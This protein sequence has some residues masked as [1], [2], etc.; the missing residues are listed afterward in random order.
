MKKSLSFTFLLLFLGFELS[1]AQTVYTFET[2][3][4]PSQWVVQTGSLTLNQ[5]HYKEGVQSLCWKTTGTSSLT[6][7]PS[8]GYMT[9]GTNGVDFQLHSPV[10]TN[11]TLKVDF[12]NGT[13][14]VRS[15]RLCVN[16]KGWRDICRAYTEFVSSAATSISKIQ[17]TLLPTDK[18]TAR[19]FY[20]DDV[21]LAS[22]IPTARILGTHWI[23]DTTYF[24]ST[25][26]LFNLQSYSYPID[27][28]TTTPTA[29]ELSGLNT[30]KSN[31][32][33]T[34]APTVGTASELAAAISFTDSLSITRNSDGSVHGLPLNLKA[35]NLT[36]AYMT[37]LVRNLE[38]LAA[39]GAA[40]ATRF[41]N[42]LDHLLDQGFADGVEYF[43]A[44]W[45]YTGSRLIPDPLFSILSS[46]STS[47]KGEVLKLC[48]WILLYGD[49]YL[50]QNQYLYSLNS[51]RIYLFSNYFMMIALNQTT[52]ALSVRELKA[53][54]R[55]LDRNGQYVPGA[56][57]FL[58]IDGTGFHHSTPYISYMIAYKGFVQNMYYL[59]G[60]PFKVDTVTYNHLKKAVISEFM[61]GH[62]G[63]I[64]TEGYMG[65]SLCGRKPGQRKL[66]FT[67]S[68]FKNF[69][70]VSTD[71]FGSQDNELA[72]AYNYVYQSTSYKVPTPANYNGFY[73]YNYGSLGVYRQANWVATMRCPTSVTKGSEIFPSENRFGRYQSHGSLEVL[74]NGYDV[75]GY[76]K[77]STNWGGWDW[78]M[79]PGTTTVQYTNWSSLMP[80]S[81]VGRFD[82]YAKTKNFSGALSWGDIGLFGCDFDQGDSWGSFSFSPTN[83]VFKKSILA[84]DGLLID[85]G[86]NISSTSS[87]LNTTTNLFQNIISTNSQ[88]LQVNGTS[89]STTLSSSLVANTANSFITPTGTGYIIP[90]GNDAINVIYGPQTTPLHTGA[91]VASPTTTLTAAKAFIVHGLK[92]SNKTYQFVVV[93]GTTATTLS[94][95]AASVNSGTTYQ[96]V[97]A[98]STMHVIYYKPRNLMAYTFFKPV[99]SV[100]DTAF[101][102]LKSISTEA[103]LL[104]RKTPSSTTAYDFAIANPNLR[105]IS[106]PNFGWIATS[107]TSVLTLKGKW[108]IKTGST[109]VTLV[110]AS[111]LETKVQIILSEGKPQYFTMDVDTTKTEV[112]DACITEKP[113]VVSDSKSKDLK[114]YL[115]NSDDKEV[116]I[117]LIYTDGTCSAITKYRIENGVVVISDAP[118]HK[119]LN[120]VKVNSGGLMTVLK[121]IH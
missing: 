65:L 18:L 66:T 44:P 7:T 91:D 31:S 107:T 37:K 113:Y 62:L 116:E 27:I 34:L 15:M 6:I 55:W 53:Y 119:G 104:E 36:S 83:L 75:S 3:T 23:N 39:D 120:L 45:D 73:A 88:A 86:S 60:T 108:L 105:P 24:S 69:I 110:S 57:D 77:D 67:Q 102:I 118:L 41:N 29:S 21:N 87:T 63:P 89:V 32:T 14:I 103:L 47:Q 61:M 19:T 1:F 92:P 84:V 100:K 22:T 40:N 54:K 78:N 9:S 98:D 43:Q 5:E 25:A 109:A 95:T 72:A 2:T 30:L 33:F 70:S 99:A 115:G 101:H 8:T 52:T 48:K 35:V 90:K 17:L 94:T 74:Y 26:S 64:N 51:D 97:N 58:K 16:F 49:F 82:Q 12:Y 96:L 4:V 13:T 121:V 117:S 106:D 68:Y 114:I 71:L 10:I 85:I 76:P 38:V 93:P 11:D 46:C 28:V 20:F 111:S 50:P 56:N 59:K 80:P 42:L 79:V 81:T 112:E